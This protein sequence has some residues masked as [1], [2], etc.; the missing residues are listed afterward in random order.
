VKGSRYVSHI[1]RMLVEQAST[2]LVVDSAR[3]L[4]E[5][6]G[7]IL[8]QL[9]ANFACDLERLDHFLALLPEG[10]RFTLEFRHNSWFCDPVFSR[11][12][13]RR[14]A[15]CIPDH[16]KMPQCLEVTAD[17]VYVRM[18]MG[19]RSIGYSTSALKTWAGRVAGWRDRGLDVF[20]YFNNDPQG[21]AIRDARAMIKLLKPGGSNQHLD[22]QVT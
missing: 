10:T 7:P 18:H 21:Y 4:G 11:L 20:V 15:L 6:L 13:E 3:G 12:R 9:Q 22:V 1:K 2:D 19:A 5:K 16:P 8:F 14:I 17:F